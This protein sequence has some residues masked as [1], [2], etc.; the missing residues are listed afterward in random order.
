[1]PTSLRA[2]ASYL[3][4]GGLG[5]I[6]LRVAR[7]MAEQGARHLVLVGRRGLPTSESGAADE[8]VLAA[9]TA[10]E[11]LGV[12][13]RVVAADVGD[14]MAAEQLLAGF[15]TAHP[16]LRGIIHAAA[17]LS[18]AS[19]DELRPDQLADMLRS[20]ATSAWMLH[21]LT[22]GLELDFFVVFSSAAGLIGSKSMAHYAAANT[23]LDGLAH[24]RRGRGLPATSVA[25]GMWENMRQEY[26]AAQR[27]VGQTGLRPMPTGRA[28]TALGSLFQSDRAQTMIAD[29]DW[30][31]LVPV[32]EARQKHRLFDRVRPVDPEK[33]HKSTPGTGQA[34]L[35]EQLQKARPRDRRELLLTHVRDEAARVLGH[36]PS[37]LDVRQGLFDMGL[38]SLMS[39]ELKSR[40]ERSAN[41]KLPMTLTFNYP[42]AEAIADFLLQ[43][44]QL[45]SDGKDGQDEPAPA[46]AG[47]PWRRALQRISRSTI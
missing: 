43:E 4:T 27:L 41:H 37:R 29:V 16:P 19:I 8:G 20:K 12:T 23:L 32:Y 10:I 44:L 3:I 36:D 15:G 21:Q 22:T 17:S 1:M 18:S 39:V 26:A 33:P 13:V 42:T 46:A 40:L 45:V 38:D 11:G 31:V 34:S 30:S 14:S 28:M 7:W 6:G 35:A 47:P 25:W 9:I 24:Y 5:S 2:D